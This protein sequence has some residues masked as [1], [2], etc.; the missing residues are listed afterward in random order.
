M[1][2]IDGLKTRIPALIGKEMLTLFRDPR[3]RIVLIMPPL[4]QLFIFAY[5]ATL[6]VR[7]VTLAIHNQ[8]SG[9]H[10]YEIVQRLHRASTFTQLLFLD[11][12]AE[13]KPMVDEQRVMAVITI[14]QDFSRD[15][16]AGVPASLQVILDGRR[17]NAAQIV[18]GYIGD[19]VTGYAGELAVEH[20]Q[21]PPPAV[22]VERNWFNTDFHEADNRHN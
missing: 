14:P 18:S 11:S 6:E 19:I 2:M 21:K 13:M 1:A 8:D 5:A 12:Q 20:G 17:F 10:G 9:R 7:N 16:E 22:L 3:G 15:I 4:L